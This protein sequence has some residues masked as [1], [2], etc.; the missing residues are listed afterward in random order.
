MNL[1]KIMYNVTNVKRRMNNAYRLIF[2]EKRLT[3]NE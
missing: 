3:H 2:N 1:K